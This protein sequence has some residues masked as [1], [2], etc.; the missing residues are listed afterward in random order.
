MQIESDFV[1]GNFAWIIFHASHLKRLSDD[2]TVYSTL[3]SCGCP[4]SKAGFSGIMRNGHLGPPIQN[5]LVQLGS[6]YRPR[7]GGCGLTVGIVEPCDHWPGPC[8][9]EGR[10]SER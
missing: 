7:G 9:G 2:C 1:S 8:R 4:R 10:N 6:D 5:L 3:Q